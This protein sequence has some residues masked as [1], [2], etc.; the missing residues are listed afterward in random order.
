MRPFHVPERMS[1]QEAG[2][3]FDVWM[4]DGALVGGWMRPGDGKLEG[5]EFFSSS[6]RILE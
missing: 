4:R 6:F 1:I 5:C 3:L 2:A